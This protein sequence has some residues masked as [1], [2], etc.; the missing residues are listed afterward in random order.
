MV[1]VSAKTGK[2]ILNL[3]G[4]TPLVKI[5]KL[6][7]NPDV[8]IY[9]KLERA[10]PSG[11]VKDRTVLYMIE[12]AEKR[13]ELTKGS[14]LLEATSGNTGISLALVGA[15]KG[16]KVVLVMSESASEER[17][18][19]A[20]GLGAEV[21]RSPAESGTDGAI[22]LANKMAKEDPKYFIT[23]QF[24]SRDNVQAHYETTGKEIWEQTNGKVTH[25]VAGVGTTGT[26]MGIS[27]RLKELNPKIQIVGAEPE[28]NCKIQG[29]KNL[30]VNIIPS[31]YQPSR[32]DE[33]TTVSDKEAFGL[34]RELA[35]KEG[36]FVGMSS[37]A[38]MH[39]ATEKAKKLKEGMIVV[40]LPDNGER[41]L[42]TGLYGGENGA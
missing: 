35:K 20:K 37:G 27:K 36:L 2:S 14:V 39:A 18:R 3:I 24:D 23:G 13:G 42:S 17:V 1:V 28:E 9:A 25:V 29:L 16:Y 4:D 10:N 31:I 8:E 30:S 41:Y 26:I 33:M 7:P 21:V 15:V 38:A 34:A 32:I 22:E 11:S 6:N 19:I 5:N 12:G 40:I